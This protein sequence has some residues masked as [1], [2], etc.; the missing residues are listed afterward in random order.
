MV[1]VG[2]NMRTPVLHA[3]DEHGKEV[4]KELLTPL[5]ATLGPGFEAGAEELRVQATRTEEHDFQVVCNYVRGGA[6]FPLSVSAGYHPWI[7]SSRIRIVCGMSIMPDIPH[8]DGKMT[9]RLGARII[10]VGV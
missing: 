10:P 1:I 4:L 6:T 2:R 9:V 3:V 7:T 5:F 8:Q